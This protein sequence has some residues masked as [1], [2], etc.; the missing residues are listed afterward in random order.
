MKDEGIAGNDSIVR[1]QHH[2][3]LEQLDLN[4]ELIVTNHQKPKVF[5]EEKK[6]WLSWLFAFIK[7]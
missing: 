3:L 6:G 1:L 2:N 4:G 7:F 5:T